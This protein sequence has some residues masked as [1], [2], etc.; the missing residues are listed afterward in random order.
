MKKI[1]FL[2]YSF[3]ILFS[4]A[5]PSYAGHNTYQCKI[6][7]IQELTKE[8]KF[9]PHKGAYKNI[10]DEFFTVNRESGEMIGFPFSTEGHRETSVLDR[11]NKDSAYK[12]FVVSH[13]PN[14]WVKY[15]YIQEF[16][17][18]SQKPFWGTADGYL[19]Y[20]GICL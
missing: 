20:S 15:I 7:Q 19:I 3:L 17:E 10:V 13:P 4:I 9:I 11:G 1:F 14:I 5:N 18:S 16:E 2:M 12:A 6:H 8:G